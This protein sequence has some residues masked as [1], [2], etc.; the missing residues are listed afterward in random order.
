MVELTPHQTTPL[1]A[2]HHPLFSQ[3]KINVWVK[4]DDLN[5]PLIQG[6]KY[7]KLYFNLLKAKEKNCDTLISFGG[8][9]S[10]HI[11]ALSLAGK[12][13]GFK[14]IGIIRGNE[15]E[16]HPEKWSHTLQQA[17]QNDMQFIFI[18]RQAYRNKN[19]P[20]FLTE[21]KSHNPTGFIIPE[22]GTNAL[23]IK[24]FQQ[25]VQD[26]N[27]QCTQCTHIFTAVGTGGT[28]AGLAEYTDK[29]KKIIGIAT[30]KQ[31]EYLTSDIKQLTDQQN[32]QLLTQYAGNGYAKS[33]DE[34]I[35]T[36]GWFE[37]SFGI[38]LDP[39]YT[40][41]M[42]FG[43]MEELK[44]GNIAKYSN[45]ILYHSGGLQGIKPTPLGTF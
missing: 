1:Q 20:T 14:T 31:A 15:L 32:W 12:E 38:K 41:K 45:V 18:N 3:A 36:Q 24:G 9:Y 26:I 34:L 37:N 21:L 17:Q 22:G 29:Q 5:H 2:I 28:L 30:L 6:N 8:A 16:N 39:I 25:T 42:V 11:A 19:Q 7:H 44:K 40:N 4:R 43:F 33:N 35:K 10:N 13:A 23:A 27:Q